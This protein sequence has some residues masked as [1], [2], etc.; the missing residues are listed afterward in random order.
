MITDADIKRINELYHKRQDG[1][2]TPEEIIE[3]ENLRAEYIKSFRENM[4]KSL[5]AT[6]IEYPDG[7][8]VNLGEKYGK[9]D[10][11]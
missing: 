6:T 2:A 1:T 3:H 10:K 7:T 9:K 11:N 5:D 4:R 8:R